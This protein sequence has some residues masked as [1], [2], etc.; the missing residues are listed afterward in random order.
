MSI[1]V[2]SSMMNTQM[3]SNINR[4]LNKMSNLE[5]QISTGRKINKPSDDPVGVTYAL[6]YRAELASNEQYQS[7]VDSAISWLDTTDATMQQATDIVTRIK[8]IAVQ[9]SSETV[10]QSGLDAIKEE[11]EELQKQLVNIGNTQIRGKYIFNGQKYDQAPYELTGGTTSYAGLDPDKA[12]VNFGISQQVNMQINTSGSDFFGASTE[13]DNLFKITDNLI[14]ALGSG[15]YS[16]IQGELTKLE[17]RNTKMQAALS[18][19]GARTNRVELMQNRLED[20]NLNLTTLQSKTEDADIASLMIQATSASTIY[21]AALQAS[22][23][24]LTPT[25]MDFMR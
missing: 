10:P 12:A 5:N 25:L 13:D 8:E 23:K 18:E 21:E 2:T 14:A 7:N 24:I 17:D 19:V 15:D 4:N 3:L 16:G 1:R 6:R 22:A 20:Q 9:G 11:M